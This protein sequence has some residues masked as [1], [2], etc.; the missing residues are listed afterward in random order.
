[1]GEAMTANWVRIDP[2]KTL[3]GLVNDIG[4]AG[5]HIKVWVEG[6]RFSRLGKR[7]WR[8]NVI[9]VKV[10]EYIAVRAGKALV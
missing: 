1:M 10:I 8:D 6:K 4:I 9:R 3:T 5:D 2:A 7:S